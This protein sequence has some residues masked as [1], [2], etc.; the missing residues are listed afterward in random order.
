MD[1]TS[2]VLGRSLGASVRRGELREERA[3]AAARW[4]DKEIR[5]LIALI[6][7]HGACKGGVWTVIDNCAR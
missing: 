7:E 3:L 4:V 5:K 2:K 6:K 1:D